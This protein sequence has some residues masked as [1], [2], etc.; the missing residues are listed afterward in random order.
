MYRPLSTTFSSQNTSSEM[1]QRRH[2][3]IGNHRK[4]ETGING[5]NGSTKIEQGAWIIQMRIFGDLSQLK[6]YFCSL[7][8][9]TLVYVVW[10]GL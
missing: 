6:G 3:A 10:Y 9:T 1:Y 2:D 7:L 5:K 4:E 8:P